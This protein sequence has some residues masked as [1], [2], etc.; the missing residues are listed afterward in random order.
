MA[1]HPDNVDLVPTF[2]QERTEMVHHRAQMLDQHVKYFV[3]F[4]RYPTRA[5]QASSTND[6]SHLLPDP[7]STTGGIMLGSAVMP[8]GSSST[9]MIPTG[10]GTL[11]IVAPPCGKLWHLAWITQD[12]MCMIQTYIFTRVVAFSVI[13]VYTDLQRLGR[14]LWTKTSC[15]GMALTACLPPKACLKAGNNK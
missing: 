10:R 14:A 2:I 8:G 13:I 5:S 7:S 12:L 3:K 1:V 11:L 15:I 4:D 6:A 9:P